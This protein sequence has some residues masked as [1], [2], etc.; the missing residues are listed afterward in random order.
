[1]SV[2]EYLLSYGRTGEFGRF[3]PDRPMNCRRGDRAVVRSHRGLELAQVLCVATPGH[4]RVLP[5]TTVGQFLRLATADDEQT[6]I[7]V[8]S[9]GHAL[10]TDAQRL[11]GQLSLSMTILDAEVLLDGEH[12][13]L[14]HVSRGDFDERPLVSSLAKTHGLHI[15]LHRLS[16]I[17]IEESEHEGCGRPGC[18]EESGGCGSCSSGGCSSCGVTKHEE[19]AHFAALREQMERKRTPLL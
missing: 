3:R 18:G 6:A 9:L 19:T 12:A 13:I 2:H 15:R 1:M 11:A 7:A 17:A 14:H 16:G 10:F 8:E 5:N 4:A